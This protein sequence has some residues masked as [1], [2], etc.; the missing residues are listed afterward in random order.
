MRFFTSDFFVKH[1][2]LGHCFTPLSVYANNFEFTEIFKLKVDSAVSMTLLSQKNF[3][4]Q[5][6]FFNLLPQRR[7]VAKFTLAWILFDCL[8]KNSKVDSAVSLL[9]QRCQ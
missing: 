2:P 5:P 8:F 7:R 3:L 4:R 1:P 6:T 9:T